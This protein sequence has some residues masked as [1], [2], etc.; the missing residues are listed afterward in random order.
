MRY[1]PIVKRLLLLVL[2]LGLQYMCV[3]LSRLPRTQ[4]LCNNLGRDDRYKR[5]H[6][7]NLEAAASSSSVAITTT[8]HRVDLCAVSRLDAKKAAITLGM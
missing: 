3:L 5:V 2:L 8:S 7:T 1:F 6:T 4:S